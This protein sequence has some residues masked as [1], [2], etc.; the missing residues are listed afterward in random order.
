VTPTPT[1]TPRW[2]DNGN[3]TITD[4]TT[5]LVWEKQSDDGSVHDKDN[6]FGW[7]VTGSTAP[8]GAAF[9][10][11][12]NTLNATGFGGYRDW[13][14]PTVDEL[15]TIVARGA[16]TPGAPVVPPK[17]NSGCRPSCTVLQCSCTTPLNYWT[18][19]PNASYDQQAWYVLFNS[20]DTGVAFKTLEFYARGVRGGY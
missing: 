7:S 8:T 12:I 10:V 4:T 3:G 16:I 6:R 11:L 20:G 5:G 1:P 19:T 17:F 2:A 9:A 13:R 18:S 15:A 14:L